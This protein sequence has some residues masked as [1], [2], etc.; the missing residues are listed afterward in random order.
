MPATFPGLILDFACEP[1][2]VGTALGPAGGQLGRRL[3][4]LAFR[5]PL[6]SFEVV[7]TQFGWPRCA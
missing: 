7:L 2:F 6:G 3:A 5:R 4:A 1:P